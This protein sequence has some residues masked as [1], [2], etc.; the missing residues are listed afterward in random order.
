MLAWDLQD[1]HHCCLLHGL[2]LRLQQLLHNSQLNEAML[3]DE[4][5]SVRQRLQ[6]SKQQQSELQAQLQSVRTAA[7]GQGAV[8]AAAHRAAMVQL[9][10]DLHESAAQQVRERP[11]LHA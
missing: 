11:F 2:Q 4:L 8:D 3:Q 5:T 9:Q 6:D 7:Q 10:Q 1:C